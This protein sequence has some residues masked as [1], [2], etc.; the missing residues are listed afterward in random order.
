MRSAWHCSNDTFFV[1]MQSLAAAKL[2]IQCLN[3]FNDTDM[4]LFALASDQLNLIDWDRPPDITHVLATVTSLN[5]NIPTP[6]F[7]FRGR[8]E[9]WEEFG[10]TDWLERVINWTAPQI[11]ALMEVFRSVSIYLA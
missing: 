5:T 6:M 9:D 4:K 10:D 7:A 3:L 1:T 2:Q 11:R 8:G